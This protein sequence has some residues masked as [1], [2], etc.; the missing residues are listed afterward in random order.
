MAAKAG[1][2]LSDYALGAP[3]S[4][5]NLLVSVASDRR[6]RRTFERGEKQGQVYH[7]TSLKVRIRAVRGDSA[8]NLIPSVINSAPVALTILELSRLVNS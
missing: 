8:A 2:K 7:C 5:C 6:P 4:N 3:A 1:L